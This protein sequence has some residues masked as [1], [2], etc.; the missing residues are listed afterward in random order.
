MR[1]EEAVVPRRSFGVVAS[2]G[3]LLE[4]RRPAAV[5]PPTPEE[6]CRT[7]EHVHVVERPAVV[8]FGRFV[9]AQRFGHAGD[10]PVVVG[11]FEGAG[12]RFAPDVRG[13]ESRG[14]VVVG[15]LLV[16]VRRADHGL[17]RMFGVEAADALQ[18]GVGDDRHGVIADHRARFARGERPNGQ[19]SRG[20]VHV[21]HTEDHVVYERGVDERL[22]RMPCAEGVPQR[23]GGVVGAPFGDPGDRSV[24]PAVLPVGIAHQ[25]GRQAGVVLRRAEHGAFVARAAF[26]GDAS[27]GFPPRRFGAGAHGV[28][29]ELGN[30]REAVFAGV[31]RADRRKADGCRE[32]LRAGGE[33]QHRLP[34]AEQLDVGERLGEPGPEIDVP[35]GDPSLR[36][37]HSGEFGGTRPA[38]FA[39]VDPRF[40]DRV[41]QVHDDAPR[42]V[43]AERISVYARAGRGRQFDRQPFV[44]QLDAVVAA[45]SPFAVVRETVGLRPVQAVARHLRAE[46]GVEENVGQIG[47]SRA[48]E[49]GVRE[50][51]DRRVVVVVARAGVPVARPRVGTELHHAERRGGAGIGVAVE[52]RADERIDVSD[53]VGGLRAGGAGAGQQHAGEVSYHGRQGRFRFGFHKSSAPSGVGWRRFAYLIP[54]IAQKRFPACSREFG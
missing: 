1:C 17:E 53:R 30:L 34:A 46:G 42:P 35:V 28:E 20:V 19:F 54:R 5:G 9:A 32:V 4:R 11:V 7:V 49:V 39:P 22:Q 50:A 47:A 31:L 33:R 23:E 38:Q 24:V 15:T 26:D 10:R 48:A 12:D 13:D 25:V 40:G 52:T 2:R 43:A 27:Q 6:A 45:R 41:R 21:E 3:E 29:V 44:G 8:R 16:A 14:H 51:V 36:A 37:A 18:V